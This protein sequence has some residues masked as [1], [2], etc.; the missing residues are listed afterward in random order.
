[1]EINENIDEDE[2]S[3]KSS[4]IK[5][6]RNEKTLFSHFEHR[7]ELEIKKKWIKISSKVRKNLKRKLDKKDSKKNA[8]WN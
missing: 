7:E 3:S 5:N 6:K 2:K 4:L 8:D 1:M